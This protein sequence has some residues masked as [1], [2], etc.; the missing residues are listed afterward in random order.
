MYATMP[1]PSIL[2]QYPFTAV[3]CTISPLLRQPMNVEVLISG[4]LKTATQP[5]LTF[6][7]TDAARQLPLVKRTSTRMMQMTVRMRLCECN[8]HV[9]SPFWNTA[10]IILQNDDKCKREC[11]EKFHI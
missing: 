11:R 8:K 7:I 4:A 5:E 10:T 9:A 3:T 2:H 1:F 6:A